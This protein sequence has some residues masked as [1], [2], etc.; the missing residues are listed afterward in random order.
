MPADF[1]QSTNLAGKVL[2]SGQVASA[3]TDT[4]VYTVPASTATK[5]STFS[6]HNPTSAAVTINKVS[7][8]PSG[9]TSDGT[10]QQLT[11]YSL[12]AYD[13]ISVEDVLSWAKGAM[14]DA[15]AK[16]VLNV[17]AAT[18]INYLLTGAE[19]S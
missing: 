10:H 6:I 13:T 5:L 18:S 19:S 2:G 9:G 16:I 15:G 4:T 17:A 12:A 7:V 3:T 14:L 11:N 1:K 8:L